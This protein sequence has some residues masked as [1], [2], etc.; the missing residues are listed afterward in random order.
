MAAPNGN[1]FYKIALAN[2]NLTGRPA[3]FTAPEQVAQKWKEYQEY[4]KTQV[5][6][7]VDFIKSGPGAGQLVNIPVRSPYTIEG[8]CISCGITGDR[9]NQMLNDEKYKDLFGILMHIRESIRN[10]QIK[11]GLVG[12]YNPMLVA[13]IQGLK[14]QSESKVDVT[15]TVTSITFVRQAVE[16]TDY[17]EVNQMLDEE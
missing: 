11:N 2:G 3:T 6:E 4:M 7:K 14:E 12:T 16:D 8:F 15:N 5:I 13:R 17:T 1:E 9:F 10:D